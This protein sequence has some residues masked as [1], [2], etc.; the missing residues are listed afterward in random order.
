MT[1]DKKNRTKVDI[2]DR[3]S[4][5]NLIRENYAW[6]IAI[7]SLMGIIGS[8]IFKFH[9]YIVSFQYFSYFGID[10]SLYSYYDNNFL[11]NI[12]FSLILIFAVVSTFYCFKQIRDNIKK[13]KIIKFENIF[14]VLWIF[15]SNFFVV[16][17]VDTSIFSFSFLF[18]I[19]TLFILECLWS[20]VIFKEIKDDQKKDYKIVDLFKIAPIIILTIILFYSLNTVIVLTSRKEYRIINDN[21]VIV[22]ATIDYYITLDCYIKDNEI[23]INRGS[24]E[25]IGSNN[26][27]SQLIKFNKVNIK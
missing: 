5:T 21:K 11:Y 24:Q 14:N 6:V 8:Y 23:T 25:K 19:L 3:V 26:V 18:L 7:L 9:E 13:R 12:I 20:K 10:H 22:Y 16:F 17:T 4:I 27:K 1:R 2:D 15:L